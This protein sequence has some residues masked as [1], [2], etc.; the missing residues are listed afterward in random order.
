MAISR[1]D[2][3]KEIYRFIEDEYFDNG[4]PI[5]QQNIV[6]RFIK[7]YH[8]GATT[9]NRCLGELVNSKSPFSLKTFYDKNRYYA[10]PTISKF[11]KGC[12][13]V[14]TTIILLCIVVD[15]LQVITW[16]FFAPFAVCIGVGFWLGVLVHLR[17][18]KKQ[19]EK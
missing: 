6:N 17:H 19:N 10:P 5:M 18:S 2:L 12:T 16:V 4:K 14:S 13:I 11:W 9:V 7:K 3:R 1:K 15:V 8:I